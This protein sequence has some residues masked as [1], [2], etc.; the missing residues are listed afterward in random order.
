VT[1]ATAATDTCAA[2]ATAAVEA[3]A[4]AA[5]VGSTAATAT[6][7]VGSTAAT[8]TAAAT[9][10]SRIGRGRERG[11]KNN[12]GNPEFECRHDVPSPIGARM[13]SSA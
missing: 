10:F 8:A 3:T 6:A 12:D 2:A 9:A 11:R 7:A 5:A 4:A 13:R 1:R